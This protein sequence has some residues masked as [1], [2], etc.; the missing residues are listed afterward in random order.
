M[1]PNPKDELW[2]KFLNQLFNKAWG[3]DYSKDT[4]DTV[5]TKI[6]PLKYNIET[7]EKI[8]ELIQQDITDSFDIELDK[9]LGIQPIKSTPSILPPAV[10]SCICCK[11]WNI[12]VEK[13]YLIGICLQKGKEK[14]DYGFICK[15]WEKI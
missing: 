5:E 4:D 14:T 10:T 2:K 8:L 6:H 3:I 15:D 7:W 11:H 12:E 1:N 13:T 9:L